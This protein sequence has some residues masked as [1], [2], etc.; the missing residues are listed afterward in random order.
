MSTR[1]NPSPFEV[2]EQN[3]NRIVI[4]SEHYSESHENVH[5]LC[6]FFNTMTF[7]EYMIFQ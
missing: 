6:T 2:V 4:E 7:S 5:L 3:G 1:F